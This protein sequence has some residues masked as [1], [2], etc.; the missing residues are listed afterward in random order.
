MLRGKKNQFY[1]GASCS[2][3]R[4][5]WCG[6]LILQVQ[7][8]N[9]PLYKIYYLLLLV[10]ISEGSLLGMQ[11]NPQ[12]SFLIR[13][14]PICLGQLKELTPEV[15]WLQ[16]L[17]PNCFCILYSH[18]MIPKPNPQLHTGNSEGGRGHRKGQPHTKGSTACA[19]PHRAC[20]QPQ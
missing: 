5:F 19:M 14:S 20:A 12:H 9:Y 10:K 16:S 7:Q 3:P 1:L 11:F 18:H 13:V 15:S 8:K 4:R 6:F 17:T 2:G